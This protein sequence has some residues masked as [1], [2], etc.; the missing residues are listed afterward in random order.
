MRAANFG[1]ADDARHGSGA[2][3]LDGLL[4]QENIWVMALHE[5]RDVYFGGHHPE[6]A[7]EQL[8]ELKAVMKDNRLKLGLATDGDADRFGVLDEGG[9]FIY[10]NELISMLVDY[11]IERRNWPGGVVW[12]V[13]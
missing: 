13:A 6:P 10:P 1:L 9:E 7:D 2:G 5:T 3:Y 4:R 8:G 11:L 12:S